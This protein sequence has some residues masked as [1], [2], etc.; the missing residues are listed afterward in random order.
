MTIIKENIYLKS[1][2][3]DFSYNLLYNYPKMTNKPIQTKFNKFPWLQDKNSLKKWQ[4]GKTGIPIVDAGM[5]ELYE[6]GWMHNRVRMI[7]GS[8]LTKN[9]LIH[10][11]A[12]ENG[13][14]IVFL[15]LILDQTLQVG[16]G[17]QG[18]ELMQAHIFQNF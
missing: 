16:S 10:W 15:M 12:G 6:T 7:V 14:L 9:L 8:F 17:F 4:F 11:K 18:V 2:E 5:K 13:F 1:G 3:R